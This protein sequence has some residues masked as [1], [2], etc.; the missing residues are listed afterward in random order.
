MAKYLHTMVRITDPGRSRAFYE[1]LGMGLILPPSHIS[2][3]MMPPRAITRPAKLAM[4]G[5]ELLRVDLEPAA[6]CLS[7]MG[8]YLR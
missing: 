4:S 5:F 8:A 3:P 1:A 7:A 6:S 2:P